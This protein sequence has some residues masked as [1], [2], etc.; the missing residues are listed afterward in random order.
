MLYRL[1]YNKVI[2]N[3]KLEGVKELFQLGMSWKQIKQ[4]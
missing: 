2:M 4:I 1:R 3:D